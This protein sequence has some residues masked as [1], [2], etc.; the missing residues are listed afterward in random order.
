MLFVLDLGHLR[1]LLT[2]YLCRSSRDHTTILIN[3]SFVLSL[4]R[5]GR[6][7]PDDERESIT[8]ERHG[9]LSTFPG[10]SFVGAMAFR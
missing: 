1:I 5:G 10:I 4:C 8:Q 7:M 6:N 9:L 3:I 2:P